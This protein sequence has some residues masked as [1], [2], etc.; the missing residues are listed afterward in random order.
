MLTKKIICT[1]I[2]LAGYLLFTAF[3]INCTAQLTLDIDQSLADYA[4]D[5]EW[6]DSNATIDISMC[7]QE[8]NASFDF[9]VDQ[10]IADY[11]ACMR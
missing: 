8:A 1:A 5:K 3:N 7:L 11:D 2:V 4:R 10:N 9:S 6:C